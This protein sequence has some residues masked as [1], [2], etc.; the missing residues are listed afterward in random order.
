MADSPALNYGPSFDSSYID[1][2]QQFA[3]FA[4][5]PN[6][7]RFRFFF[8]LN[9]LISSAVVKMKEQT[10]SNV[11]DL[12]RVKLWFLVDIYQLRQGHLG[13]VFSWPH[14]TRG[15]SA[16]KT[17]RGIQGRKIVRI[18]VL[19]GWVSSFTKM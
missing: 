16:G 8:C 2:Y 15:I 1:I 4:L 7:S 12:P 17:G 11:F 10:H 6:F 19:I 9:F 18:P 3:N 13:S 14:R 5:G